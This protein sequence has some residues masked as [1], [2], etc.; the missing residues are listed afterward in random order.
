M[1]KW[2]YLHAEGEDVDGSLIAFDEED[3]SLEDF[4]DMCEREL[5]EY[6][7]GHIDIYSPD[8]EFLGDVEV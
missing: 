4:R 6:G 5:R 3:I 2:E 1:D 8:E 7:G